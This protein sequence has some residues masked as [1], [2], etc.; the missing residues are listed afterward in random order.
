MMFAQT[1][2]TWL[3]NQGL[4]V[5][6]LIA[7]GLGLYRLLSWTGTNVV[8][9][10]KDAAVKHLDT[11]GVTLTEATD[12]LRKINVKLD[13]MN[14]THEDFFAESIED[15]GRMHEAIANVRERVEKLEERK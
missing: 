12:S 8:T 11:V 7:I 5:G 3:T 2:W 14:D 13:V 9:P 10:M 15:R 4:A 6:L 1:D